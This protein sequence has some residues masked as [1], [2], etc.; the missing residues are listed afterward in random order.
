MDD[1]RNME[2]ERAVEWAAKD[3]EMGELYADISGVHDS[4]IYVGMVREIEDLGKGGLEVGVPF[5]AIY[6]RATNQEIRINL[7]QAFGLIE[8]I[9]RTASVA[10]YG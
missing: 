1:E 4:T 2:E 8:A 9:C 6:D 7:G 3:E 10:I 5:V